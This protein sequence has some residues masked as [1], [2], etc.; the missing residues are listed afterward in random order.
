MIQEAIRFDQALMYFVLL[1]KA[2]TYEQVKEARLE[3]EDNQ[4]VFRGRQNERTEDKTG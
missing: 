1:R 4:K 2:K 3:Y